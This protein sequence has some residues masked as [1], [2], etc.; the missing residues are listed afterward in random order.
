[1]LVMIQGNDNTISLLILWI[2]I[3]TRKTH[4][5]YAINTLVTNATKVKNR[6]LDNQRYIFL[7]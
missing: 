2:V 4:Y 5:H 1:M 7:E 3:D 6:C